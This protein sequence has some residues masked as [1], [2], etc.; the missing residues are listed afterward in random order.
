MCACVCYSIP[1]YHENVHIG[2]SILKSLHCKFSINP[3][4][5]VITT[6][7]KE[8]NWIKKK[9]WKISSTLLA[10]KMFKNIFI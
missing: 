2:I 8:E 6:K 3:D 5:N 7:K 4:K 10:Q 9:S 1:K